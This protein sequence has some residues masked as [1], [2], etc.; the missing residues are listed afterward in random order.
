MAILIIGAG[1]VGSQIARILV[2]QG[3][4]PV[5]MDRAHQPEALG[6]IVDLARV[7][8]VGGDVLQPL[9]LT[10]V[11]REHDIAEIVHM[12]ANPMLTLGAQ[13]DPYAAVQLNIMGTMNV[14]E[15]GRIHRIKRVVVASSNVLSHF[16]AGGE[17]GGDAA[18]EEAFPRPT[19]FYATTKQAVENLGLN[20]ARWCGVEFAALRYGAVFG[21][22]SGHG[23]GG[24]SNVMREAVRRALAGEEAVLPSGGMEWVYSKDAAM[25]TVLAL[26]AGNLPSRIFNITM[27]VVATPEDMADALRAV[28]PGTKVRIETPAAAAVSLP[29]MT[30]PSDLGLAGSVLNYAPRFGLIDALRDFTA[31]LKG[32]DP[33]RAPRSV[34]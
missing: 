16:I 23:G 33:R 2:E 4:K 1:L 20:Y 31:W 18:K 10:K 17:G 30:R 8:Q 15:A 9:E 13:R 27:G 11:L 21:P 12:A 14:L 25:G 28:I 22:W 24:P 5:L 19:T 6:E 29:N 3:E 26:K 34:I 7:T 32:V